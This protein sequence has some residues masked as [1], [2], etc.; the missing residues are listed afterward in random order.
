[1]IERGN[2][3]HKTILFKHKH[4]KK[5]EYSFD[6]IT[7]I[8]KYVFCNHICSFGNKT[9]KKKTTTNSRN[10]KNKTIQRV[11]TN[12]RNNKIDILKQIG[13]PQSL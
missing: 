9:T 8:I 2:S 4:W 1:M 13:L 11:I 10:N 6:C 3:I 5:N 12:N 7:S